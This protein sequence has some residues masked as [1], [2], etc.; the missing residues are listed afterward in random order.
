[1]SGSGVEKPVGVGV[2]KG[3]GSVCGPSGL[4]PLAAIWLACLKTREGPGALMTTKSFVPLCRLSGAPLKEQVI[5][6]SK[7][8][9][10][11]WHL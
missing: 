6:P 10:L 4:G 3:T 7:S 8:T 2:L 5:P 9:S 11:P 1:M